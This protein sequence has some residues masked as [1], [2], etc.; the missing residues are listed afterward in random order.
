MLSSSP[1]A[2]LYRNWARQSVCRKHALLRYTT[3]STEAHVKKQ[4]HAK[5]TEHGL[6]SNERDVVTFESLGVRTPIAASL[7][8]AFPDV[9]Q[10]TTM[11]R[12]LISAVIGRQDILLQDFT[13]TGKCVLQNIC[14][15]LN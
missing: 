11:Q 4:S 9:Q 13:G 10:P 2:L 1:V 5:S 14:Y 6:R 7:R 12:K 8:V 3:R 15:D